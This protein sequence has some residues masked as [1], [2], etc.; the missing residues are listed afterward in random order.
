M[1]TSLAIVLAV[2]AD[3]DGIARTKMHVP[4]FAIDPHLV[5][6]REPLI[7]SNMPTH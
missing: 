4:R 7:T 1:K 2:V 6:Y 3:G 5:A